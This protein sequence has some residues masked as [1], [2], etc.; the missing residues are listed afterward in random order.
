MR[1]GGWDVGAGR[2]GRSGGSPGPDRLGYRTGRDKRGAVGSRGGKRRPFLN[3]EAVG[4]D[5]ERGVMV[6]ASPA[7]AFVVAEPQ[8][9]LELLI[10]PLNAPAQFGRVN[11]LADCDRLRQGRSQYRVGSVSPSGHSMSSHSSGQG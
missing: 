3:Q 5:A 8:L 7:P 2:S 10:I 4:C 6:K 9:L 11:Q 1:R